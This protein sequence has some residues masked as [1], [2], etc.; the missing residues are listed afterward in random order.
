MFCAIRQS[1]LHTSVD[2]YP[3]IFRQAIG[4]ATRFDECSNACLAEELPGLPF[5]DCNQ[6][7]VVE[8]GG[9]QPHGQIA[10][11]AQCFSVQAAR[12]F[13]VLTHIYWQL[14]IRAEGSE[15]KTGGSQKLAHGV[16]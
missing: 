11:L 4:I 8:Q 12:I 3:V 14:S 2:A 6:I 15:L 16:M 1:F 5:Q 10:Y 9:A 13:E 7:D